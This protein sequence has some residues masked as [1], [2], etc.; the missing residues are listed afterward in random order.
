MGEGEEIDAAT[1][2]SFPPPMRDVPSTEY[3]CKVLPAMVGVPGECVLGGPTVVTGFY[4]L[5]GD[6][7]STGPIGFRGAFSGMHFPEYCGFLT[8][9]LP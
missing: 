3:P 9:A 5:D 1:S 2:T 6:V 4:V 8:G 7:V